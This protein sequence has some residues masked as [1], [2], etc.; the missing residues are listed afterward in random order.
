[1]TTTA[2]HRLDL[3]TAVAA[4]VRAPSVHNTQPWKFRLLD[5]A[6]EVFADRRRQLR[7]ADPDATALRVSCGAAIF[8]LRLAFAQLGCDAEVRLLPDWRDPDLLARVS[9]GQ[10]R[11]P[12]PP[13]T[14]LFRAI[15]KRHSNRRP[16]IDTAVPPDVRA[17]LVRAATGEGGWLDL[18][19]GPAA[20]VTIAELVGAADRILV[21][22]DG[23]R[24]ELRQWTRD[25]DNASDGVPSGAG[26]PL[27]EPYDLLA[28]RDFH[29]PPRAPG[30]DY[31]TDPLVAVLGAAS[32]SPL[33]DLVAGQ[34]LQSVLLTATS[35]GLA[36]SLMSQ[37]IGVP[38]I[39]EQLRIGLRRYGSPHML[40]RTGYGVPG[41]PTPRRPI[42][43]VLVV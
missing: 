38:G 10:R 41:T 18:L 34:A 37:P 24:E 36:T 30:R 6:I 26:G 39:R 27:P 4:A 35:A 33:D 7:V 12:T 23:Y 32:D 17:Q 14:A 1:M 19:I 31:E 20:L 11:P 25:D 15:S 13:Q 43:D 22:S 42:A 2:S 9:A 21:G 40:L 5:G 29:G 3:V 8:N 28:R 16:F